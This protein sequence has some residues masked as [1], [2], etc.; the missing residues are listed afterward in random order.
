MHHTY[1]N[2]HAHGRTRGAKSTGATC[3][4]RS[5]LHKPYL[6]VWLINDCEQAET[7]TLVFSAPYKFTPVVL[8]ILCL[9]KVCNVIDATFFSTLIAILPHAVVLAS[10]Y[11]RHVIAVDAV[12]VFFSVFYN[13]CRIIIRCSHWTQRCMNHH[14]NVCGED[15]QLAL[16]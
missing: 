16:S 2:N 15:R 12:D 3:S 10:R 7:D 1:C 5:V 14:V 13:C 4:R 9:H 11:L 8:C 6:H